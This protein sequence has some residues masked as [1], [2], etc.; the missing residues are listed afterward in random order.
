MR[1]YL[2]GTFAP[3]LGNLRRCACSERAAKVGRQPWRAAVRTV[4]VHDAFV[5]GDATARRSSVPDEGKTCSARALVTLAAWI[6]VA[7][8][9]AGLVV[10]PHAYQA[11]AVQKLLPGARVVPSSVRPNPTSGVGW[12]VG[13]SWNL[14]PAQCLELA[15][16]TVDGGVVSGRDARVAHLPLEARADW[17]ARWD[18]RSDRVRVRLVSV[19]WPPTPG[20]HTVEVRCSDRFARFARAGPVDAVRLRVYCSGFASLSA[21]TAALRRA[22]WTRLRRVEFCDSVVL[23]GEPP[24]G[25]PPDDPVAWALSLP[26][27]DTIDLDANAV[28][29]VDV[30]AV[31]AAIRAR[32]AAG[33]QSVRVNFAG[34]DGPLLRLLLAQ[35]PDTVRVWSYQQWPTRAGLDLADT[36]A[37][38]DRHGQLRAVWLVPGVERKTM[39]PEMRDAGLWRNSP[40]LRSFGVSRQYVGPRRYD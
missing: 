32:A 39:P 37:A 13:R 8:P 30:D 29:G 21:A 2:N 27:V 36:I 40:H 12:S 33:H 17:V 20:A 4:T 34:A 1:V 25:E 23:R 9:Q 14:D 18:L 15:A 19:A 5:G 16:A 28:R 38:L 7:F 10:M 22:E 26:R 6:A 24:D 3:W 35:P 11:E 31:G